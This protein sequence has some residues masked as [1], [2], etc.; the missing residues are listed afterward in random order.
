MAVKSIYAL[1]F[2]T[3]T[4]PVVFYVGCTNDIE[5]RRAE[6]KRNFSDVR[7]VEYNTHKYRWCRALLDLDIPTRLEVLVDSAEIDED[8]EYEW[9][10]KFARHNES[11]AITFYDNLPLTNMR[12]GDFLEEMLRD[13]TVNTRDDIRVFRE[14]KAAERAAKT[15]QYTRETEVAAGKELRRSVID[16]AKLEGESNK[17]EAVI[18]NLQQVAR[19]QKRAAEIQKARQNSIE[20][21]NDKLLN[22]NSDDKII[23]RQMLGLDPLK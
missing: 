6:H 17:T 11:Q 19:E 9:V 7:H 3:D 5:R 22:G 4:G 16:Y 8:S 21:W 10:L 23:A 18:K 2:D 12:A 13:K 14:R 15:V 20:F 1:V